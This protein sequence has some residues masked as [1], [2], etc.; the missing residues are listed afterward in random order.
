[1]ALRPF[2]SGRGCKI[3][4]DLSVLSRTSMVRIRRCTT[5]RHKVIKPTRRRFLGHKISGVKNIR[6]RLA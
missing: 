2:W 3:P 1:M 4:F 6:S 5:A